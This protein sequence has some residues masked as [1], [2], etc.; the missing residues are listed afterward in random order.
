MQ[1]FKT[2]QLF[3]LF[4]SSFV[5]ITAILILGGVLLSP[6][7]LRNAVFLGL[8]LPRLVLAVGLFI[9]FLF[10]AFLSIRTV[11]DQTWADR[12]LEGWFGKIRIRLLITWLAGLS[13]GIGWIGCFLPDYRAG[14]LAVHWERMRPAMNNHEKCH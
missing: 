12:V 8:S 9:A 14:I 1:K 11:K 2:S 4:Y 5:A 3:F 10:F 7:E 13:F 6:S